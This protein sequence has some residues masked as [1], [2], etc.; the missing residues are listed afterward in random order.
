TLIAAH[1]PDATLRSHIIGA[2]ANGAT[3]TE[4]REVIVHTGYY[5][6]VG[7]VVS[8]RPVAEAV[9]SARREN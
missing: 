9:F 1:M 6:G 3:E 4:I 5:A 2:L 8:A 7:V